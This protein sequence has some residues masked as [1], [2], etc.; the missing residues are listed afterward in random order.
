MINRNFIPLVQAFALAIIFC[1]TVVPTNAAPPDAAAAGQSS[2]RQP[3]PLHPA[4]QTKLALYLTAKEACEKWKAEPNKVKILDVRT[5]EEFVFVGHPD[6]AWNIPFG[7]VSYE[8]QGGENKCSIKPNPNFLSSVKEWA[9]PTDTIVCMCRSGGRG[10]MAVNLLAQ[11]GFKNVFNMTDGFEGDTVDDPD[12]I[13]HGKR[14]KNGWKNS[15][16]PWN[17]S[18]DPERMLL[19]KH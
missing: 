19:G 15:A 2:A 9:K 16:L 14:M 17:Y 6:M 18:V 13:Y 7:F 11:A 4:K 1:L 12:S 8:E 10:A 5:P 3:S